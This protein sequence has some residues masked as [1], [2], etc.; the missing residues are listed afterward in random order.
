MPPYIEVSKVAD[1]LGMDNGTGSISTIERQAMPGNEDLAE[2]TDDVVSSPLILCP[3][4]EDANGN[5]YWVR[6]GSRTNT[7]RNH[8]RQYCRPGGTRNG[9]RWSHR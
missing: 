6:L 1:G 8:A 5:P 7:A 3:V 2:R 9:L 4:S